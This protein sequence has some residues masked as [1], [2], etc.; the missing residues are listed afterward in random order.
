MSDRL[1]DAERRALLA[2]D[3]V[4]ALEP[5]EAAELGFL[6]DVLADP[7]MWAEPNAA[8]EDKVMHAVAQAPAIDATSTTSQ[9]PTPNAQRRGTV[10]RSRRIMLGALAAAASIALVVG[11]LVATGTTAS[12]DYQGQLTATA[13][14]PGARASAEVTRNAAGFRVTVDA[15]GLRPLRAGAFYQAWLKNASGGLVSIGTFSSSDGAITLWSGVSPQRYRGISV[16]IEP[17][18]NNPASS[19]RRVLIGEL[20]AN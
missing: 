11:V 1:T 17:D 13:L 12:P 4:D 18:D 5:D 2:G 19:G 6:A 16:T 8:L 20:H 7:S 10:G 3:H 9:P 15:H 14:A